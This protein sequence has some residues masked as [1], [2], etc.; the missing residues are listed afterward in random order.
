MLTISFTMNKIFNG[1]SICVPKKLDMKC[2]SQLSYT[3]Y[4]TNYR[5]AKKFCQEKIFT[6]FATCLHGQFLSREFFVPY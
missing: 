2:V 4:D 1:N 5:I 3:V 6:N